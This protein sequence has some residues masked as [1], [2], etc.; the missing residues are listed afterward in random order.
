MATE[1]SII[2]SQ[3]IEKAREILSD[4]YKPHGLRE[5]NQKAPFDFTHV[6]AAVPIGSFNVLKYGSAVEITPEPFDDFFMLEM[7][8]QE[9]V[10][11]EAE[12]RASVHSDSDT[13]LFLP[14]HVRFASVWRADSLQLMLQV[15]RQEVLR[16]WQ[17]LSGDPTSQLP[18]V[19]PEINLKTP[20]GW[21]IRQL[22][23]LLREELNL[24]LKHGHEAVKSS[25]LASAV[26]DATLIYFR[27]H[28]AHTVTGEA[29]VLPSGLRKCIRYIHNNLAN[30]LSTPVLV[31]QSAT[32]ERALYQQF[33]R[34]LN[35]TPQAYIRLAR[36][37]QARAGLLAGA[38]VSQA[39]T[40]AGFRHLGRFSAAY[41]KTYGEAPS[42]TTG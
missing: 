26:I 35:R 28:Q 18:R 27:T 32:S 8:L 34:F 42:Q 4:R 20:E 16:R 6:S 13:A 38:T 12:G 25:P 7:P 15:H 17:T 30:D 10:D 40:S 14:P 5:L 24:S 3:D 41:K 19:H 36:L 23:L 31:R 37:K 22:L 29:P 2:H 9:G 21:R 33:K 39:A 1:I 11:I